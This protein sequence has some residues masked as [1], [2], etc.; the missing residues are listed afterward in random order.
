MKLEIY[1][2]LGEKVGTLVNEFQTAGK[3][4]KIWNGKNEDENLVSSGVYYYR[5]NAGDFEISK[6]MI[7]LR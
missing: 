5:I 4:Q 6:K 7:L 3:Y 2:V 1:N